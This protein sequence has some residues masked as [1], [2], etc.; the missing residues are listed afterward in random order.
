MLLLRPMQVQGPL[1]QLLW[2]GVILHDLMGSGE[3]VHCLGD[4]WVYSLG[5]VGSVVQ[6]A[7]SGL[8]ALLCE[9]PSGGR[10]HVLHHL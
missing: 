10:H 5:G 2:V 9:Q 1:V 6:C 3:D 8:A 4:L 7:Q